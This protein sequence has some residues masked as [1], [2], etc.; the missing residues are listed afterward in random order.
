MGTRRS[1]EGKC[2]AL[3]LAIYLYHKMG[4]PE[5][6]YNPGI[7][8]VWEGESQLFNQFCPHILCRGL[9]AEP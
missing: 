8:C 5:S 1:L 9:S 6:R 2:W 4:S 3:V 7:Q